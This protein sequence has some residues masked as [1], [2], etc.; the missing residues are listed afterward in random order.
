MARA[1]VLVAVV[2]AAL[3]ALVW[4]RHTVAPPKVSGFLEADAI[5]LGSRMGGRVKSV[6]AV[7][8]AAVKTGE[9]LVELEPYDLAERRAGAVA[10]AAVRKAEHARLVAGAR[11]EEIA[12]AT[13]RAREAAAR[14]ERLVNGPRKQEIEAAQSHEELAVAH[15]ELARKTYERTKTLVGIGGV[16]QEELDRA[17]A[18]VAAAE[19]ALR[20]RQLDVAVLREGSR[21]EDVA[22]ARASVA[23][24]AAVLDLLRAGSRSEDI[25][26]AKAAADSADAAVAAIDRQVDELTVRAPSDGVVEAVDLHPGDLVAPSAPML[27]IVDPRR[28]WVRA[29]LPEDR[30][31]VKTGAVLDVGVDAFPARRFKAH[32]SFVARQAEFTPGN[33]QTPD[34]RAKQVFRVKVELDEGT[35]VLRPGMSA[36]VWLPQR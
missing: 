35:D 20:V 36:D 30:L 3:T 9:V 26:A 21:S 10:V 6:H 2:I 17:T 24:A 8:G 23:E 7:E 34:Q 5:R 13:A 22:A 18:V 33:V 32:V 25:A 16:T 11:P 14:L 28:L 1:L 31:D 12:Q 19:S 15:L 29:Y 4:S 27:S